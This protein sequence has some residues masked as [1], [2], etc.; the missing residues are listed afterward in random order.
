MGAVREAVAR[1]AGVLIRGP[2]VILLWEPE[3]RMGSGCGRRLCSRGRLPSTSR[4]R[5]GSAPGPLPVA[6][7]PHPSALAAWAPAVPDRAG[8]LSRKVPL[9]LPSQYLWTT[10]GSVPKKIGFEW[11]FMYNDGPCRL[12]YCEKS[13]AT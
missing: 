4:L 11:R 10:R 1:Q 7:H 6:L 13:E 3:W 8:A 12:F 2:V 5:L 9:Q